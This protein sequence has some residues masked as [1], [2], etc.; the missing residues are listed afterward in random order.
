M[1]WAIQ[2]LNTIHIFRGHLYYL[3][4]LTSRRNWRSFTT[5]KLQRTL[6]T[7]IYPPYTM[8]RFGLLERLYILCGRKSACICRNWLFLRRGSNKTPKYLIKNWLKKNLRPELDRY[9]GD[10]FFIFK[11]INPFFILSIKLN[12]CHF[13]SNYLI[14]FIYVTRRFEEGLSHLYAKG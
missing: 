8:I 3:I 10:H 7:K 11:F 5:S 4:N 6:N 14:N 13:S 1:I 12:F 9:F 2:H